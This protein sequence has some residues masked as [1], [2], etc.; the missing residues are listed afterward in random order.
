MTKQCIEKKKPDLDY[1]KIFPDIFS[2]ANIWNMSD[3]ESNEEE[4]ILKNLTLYFENICFV[5]SNFWNKRDEHINTDYAVTGC[6]L[7]V[8]PH[9][10]EDFFKMHKIKIIFR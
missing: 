10:R 3:D 5:I 4:S 8:M 7:C 1:Q 9:I 2:L 6:M